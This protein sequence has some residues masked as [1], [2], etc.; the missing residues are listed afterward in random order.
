MR[1][2]T[3]EVSGGF[4]NRCPHGRWSRSSAHWRGQVVEP[5]GG[6]TGSSSRAEMVEFI[7]TNSGDVRVRNGKLEVK[8]GVITPKTGAKYIRTY[9]DGKWTDNLLALPRYRTVVTSSL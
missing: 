6:K 2:V 8:V 1:P 7:E 9:A 5:D 4:R 3:K